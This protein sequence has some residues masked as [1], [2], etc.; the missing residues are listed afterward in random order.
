MCLQTNT[1]RV[2]VVHA[3]KHQYLRVSPPVGV[4]YLP[5]RLH[6]PS[7][8]ATPTDLT[9]LTDHTHRPHRLHSQATLTTLTGHTH[10]PHWPSGVS[11]VRGPAGRWRVLGRTEVRNTRGTLSSLIRPQAAHL[12]TRR[13]TK[14]EWKATWVLQRVETVDEK[15]TLGRSWGG[16][17]WVLM[18][19]VTMALWS[20][21]FAACRPA[22]DRLKGFI[23]HTH[24]PK[25]L[26]NI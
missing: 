15:S 5:L 26:S 13:A 19:T 25:L 24:L 23:S 22:R 21:V 17:W 9:D 12:P 1:H 20:R 7:S 8:Q 2:S 4:T 6:S 3:C 10:H 11:A 16:N 14:L 18:A